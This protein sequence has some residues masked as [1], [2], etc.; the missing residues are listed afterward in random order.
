[1]TPE[2][3]DALVRKLEPLA[4]E[5][6]RRYSTRLALLAG[7]GYA[8]IAIALLGLIALGALVVYVALSS[9]GILLKFLIPIGAVMLVILR[10]LWVKIEPPEGVPVTRR[11]APDLFQML[12]EVRA[13]VNGPK[14]HRVLVDGQLN[15]G[16]VQIP[17]LGPIGW[18][19]N[20]LLIG[21]PLLEALS[22]DELRAVIAHEFGHLSKRH[23]RFSAW[24][25]RIR[26]TWFQLLAG[27]EQR[28]SMASG[29]F[30]R[31]FEWYVPYFDA[32]SFVLMRAHE[33]EADRAAAE[34]A[35][36]RNA[37]AALA[38]IR[39]ADRALATEYWPNLF[40]RARTEQEPPEA[41]FAPMTQFLPTVRSRTEREQWLRNDLA[42]PADTT[43]THPSLADRMAA[44]GVDPD[45]LLGSGDGAVGT[46][47][48]RFLGEARPALLEQVAR[49]WREAVRSTWQ[50]EWEEAEKGRLRLG[51]LREQGD[52]S[53]DDLREQAILTEQL[54]DAEQALPIYEAVLSRAPDDTQSHFAIG[55]ILLERSDEHGL[56]HLERAMEADPEA[57]LPACQIAFG[58]LS[59]H[60]RTEEADRYR[61]RAEQHM[62]LLEQ[63]TEERRDVVAD[64][65]FEPHDLSEDLVR[66]I[67]RTLSTFSE[68][69]DA[70]LVQK[71][72]EHLR[73]EYPLYVIGVVPKHRW[74]Q[75]WK[76]KDDDKPTL[77]QEVAGSLELPVDFHV[78][79]PGPRSDVEE[80]LERVEGAK[81]YSG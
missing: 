68:V 80:R 23:G 4:R 53:P 58:Y 7:V 67:R 42:L 43:D 22:P 36:A 49:Q 32:H 18:Q 12:A 73:N 40:K 1:M 34:V 11:D 37:A 77:A 55:R 78:L 81:I 33:L 16:I 70:Y 9:A 63:A 51:D 26:L 10:S 13:A 28:R 29:L 31:F 47:G 45:E 57:V 52:L 60:D 25:Y 50:E 76:D 65:E 56:E 74:R 66:Q 75:A 8:Y 54:E 14:V 21:L 38:H 19:K 64:D 2:Q 59:D 30:R 79:V 20:Y 6:P 71:R 69:A 5:N 62:Q 15:A 41:A 27:L 61:A 35:G 48:D 39:F 17:R 3:W 72:V 44:L 46:A 24:I